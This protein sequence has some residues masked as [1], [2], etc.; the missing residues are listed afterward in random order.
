[1]ENKI[2]GNSYIRLKNDINKIYKVTSVNTIAQLVDATQKN[3]KR[4]ALKLSDVELADSQD[5]YRYDND[6]TQI[7]Y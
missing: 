7:D 1:M 6:F 2:T 3:G 4:V 5:I